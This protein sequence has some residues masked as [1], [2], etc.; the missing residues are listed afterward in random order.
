MQHPFEVLKPEYA[1]LL[2]AMQVREECR[3]MVDHSAAKLL[4]F[5]SRYQEV[6]AQNGVPIVFMAA[7]FER[8]ASS[9]FTKNPAQGWPLNSISRDIPHNGPFSNWPAAALAAYHLNGL[10]KVGAANWTWELICFYGELFNG[11]GYRDYHHMHSPY[12]WAGTNIQ[13]IGKYTEDKGFDP[14]VM[15]R[16]PGIIPIARCMVELDPTLALPSLPFVPAP[17]IASGIAAEQDSDAKWVQQ[18][19]NALG[20][21]PALVVTGNYDRATFLAIMAF[22]KNYGLQVDGIVGPKTTAALRFLTKAPTS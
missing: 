3:A 9:D 15:D 5:K 10:D 7:S 16:Q 22:Q 14:T 13:T 2:L 18:S 12:L 20:H 11:M 21:T 4:G 17:P 1:R 8:E 19:L 6:S